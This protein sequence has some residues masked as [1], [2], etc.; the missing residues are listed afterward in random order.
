MG[1]QFKFGADPELF[2]LDMTTNKYISGHGLIKGDKENPFPVDLGAVQVDGMALEF[3]IEPATNAREF[4]RNINIVRE[5]MAR[6]LPNHYALMDVPAIEFQK[7][8]WD[9]TPD[10]DKV[11]GCTPDYNAWKGGVANVIEDR[12]DSRLRTASGHIHIGWGSGYSNTDPA[13]LELCMEVVRQLDASVGLASLEWD[14]D[15]KRREMY[16]KAGAF[17]PK[18]YGVEYRVLSNRWLIS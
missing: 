8:S 2:V 5:Q 4:S 6:M 3:N 16:G 7:D 17:R 14:P 10:E 13:H 15:T 18:P 1:I 12:G 11:L 9:S